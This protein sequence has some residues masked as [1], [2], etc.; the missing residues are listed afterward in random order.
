MTTERDWKGD[1]GP[2]RRA[3]LR[4]ALQR[5]F[6]LFDPAQQQIARR[7][8]AD[9]GVDLDPDHPTASPSEAEPSA[10]SGTLT[11]TGS[12]PPPRCVVRERCPHHARLFT[13]FR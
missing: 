3:G 8:L 1:T 2:Q 7:V 13:N 9:R 11:V 5:A 6:A 4:E 12:R 10:G